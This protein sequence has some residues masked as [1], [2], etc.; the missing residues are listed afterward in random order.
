MPTTLSATS[1]PSMTI[2]DD[3]DRYAA[4]YNSLTNSIYH[5][6][7][8]RK[9]FD[10]YGL[11]AHW[12]V[13]ESHG[14]PTGILPLIHQSSRLFGHRLYSLP[15]VDEAGAIGDQGAVDA[16]LE[17]A[18]DMANE[19]GSKFSVIVKQ[20]VLGPQHGK[21]ADWSAAD[22]NKVLLWR[23]LSASAEDLWKEFSPKVR[24]QVRKAEKNGLETVRGGAELVDAFFQVYS[25]NMRDLGSP[26]HSLKFFRQL[27]GGLGH[28][29]S[30][31]CTRLDGVTVGAG[32]VLDN[33][34]SLDIPWASSLLEHN[35][36]CVNH[37]MYWQILS[38][39]CD[40]G[41][42][43]FH[44]GRSS[45]GSGQYKFKK[46][47]G[48]EE[49]PLAWLNHSQVPEEPPSDDPAAIKEQFGLAQQLWAK[50]P[51]WASRRLG[52]RFIRNAP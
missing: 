51:L 46:Q 29:A 24:N 34:P 6:P 1:T 17:Y 38:D 3:P 32:L 47:W 8:W 18:S 7:G 12:L 4:A 49:I 39:A 16:L 15:W 20:P 40:S 11:R 21:P 26:S 50:L 45:L 52:P 35:R 25:Q 27:L 48:A 9:A 28:R 19:L 36:R 37:A 42:E 33:R 22:S 13:A 10:V 14:K 43:R 41:F 5:H 44:F 23:R 2:A 30:L 31:Y